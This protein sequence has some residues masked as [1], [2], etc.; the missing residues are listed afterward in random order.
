MKRI[1]KIPL[2]CLPHVLHMHMFVIGKGIVNNC[3][4]NKA[5]YQ[6]QISGNHLRPDP[7]YSPTLTQAQPLSG[8]QQQRETISGSK[9]SLVQRSSPSLRK[10]VTQSNRSLKT[11]P[12][13]FLSQIF[14][15]C[16]SIYKKGDYIVQTS[17]IKYP[18]LIYHSLPYFS[19]FFYRIQ[20]IIS[21]ISP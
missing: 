18:W 16:L 4:E 10:Q 21:F 8:V 15:S 7:C 3:G 17:R 19:F 2:V 14:Y 5:R 20:E 11:C 1:L 9:Q 6:I 13:P 12:G